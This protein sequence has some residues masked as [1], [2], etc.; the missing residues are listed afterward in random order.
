MLIRL[1]R[2]LLAALVAALS[3]LALSSSAMA[4][5]V[6]S[7]SNSDNI[8]PAD[9]VN[10]APGID[11]VHY[12]SAIDVAGLAG[13]I[14]G[15]QVDLKGVGTS[16]TGDLDVLLVSPGGQAV[17]LMSD[18][19]GKNPIAFANISF[20]DTSQPM[21]SSDPISSGFYRPT[22]LL[23]NNDPMPRPAPAGPYTDTQLAA[24]NGGEPNGRWSLYVI[25]DAAA[26]ENHISLGW[27]LT[28]KT[29]GG[30]IFRNSNPIVG[31][32]RE[33]AQPPA[34][35]NPYPSTLDVAGVKQKVDRVTVTLHDIDIESAADMDLLLVGPNGTSV[36]LTS[37]VG[38]GNHV[39]NAD[40]GF[41][42]AA[43]TPIE[44]L[45]TLTPGVHKPSDN[46]ANATPDEP[47]GQDVFPAPAPQQEHGNLLKAF[48]GSDPNGTWKLFLTD[49]RRTEFNNVNGGWSLNF[50]LS[51]EPIE[52]PAP[53]PAPEPAPAPA[54]APEP[55]PAPAPAPGPVKPAAIALTSLKLKPRVFR[56]KEGTVVS[57]KLSAAAKVKF[58]ALR[59]GKKVL[60]ATQKGKA[61]ANKLRFKPINLRPGKYTLVASA[62]KSVRT[63]AFQVKPRR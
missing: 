46:D 36:V 8:R 45:K 50:T 63:V 34:L 59:K 16:F 19:S 31:L 62:G 14:T 49:D 55:A 47:D 11:P 20:S 54:P 30:K 4:N 41:D 12:P 61:G 37:D 10:G 28:L 42:D 52:Q 40:L 51:D 1:P 24:F 7:F 38:S 13:T 48:A 33:T 39:S 35:A 15:V 23:D 5:D 6:R 25:D 32:D 17:M 26:D 43:A 29:T 27:D 2:I 44:S 57:Y 53:A 56:V 18:V 58:T 3:A 21:P 60:S 9:P 22:N